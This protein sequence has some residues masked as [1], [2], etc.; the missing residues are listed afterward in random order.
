MTIYIGNIKIIGYDIKRNSHYVL[1]LVFRELG[2][3]T[4]LK[5]NSIAGSIH[6]Q[7]HFC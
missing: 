2:K 4:L 3:G 5:M 1:L 7:P 6:L